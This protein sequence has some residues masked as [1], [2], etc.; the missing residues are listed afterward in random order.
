MLA[1]NGITISGKINLYY[2]GNKLTHKI[3][4]SA[5]GNGKII[6]VELVKT[7]ATKKVSNQITS[8]S[9]SLPYNGLKDYP[10]IQIH[11]MVLYG[12]VILAHDKD[13]VVNHMRILSHYYFPIL[14]K[15]TI[16][17]GIHCVVL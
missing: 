3:L 12:Y 16:Y 7:P 15:L 11:G 10:E 6:D 9:R 5:R 17:T 8:L 14:T 1:D 2:T 4:A 13:T